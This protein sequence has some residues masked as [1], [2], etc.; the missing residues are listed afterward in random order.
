MDYNC[1]KNV[2][3]N[4]WKGRGMAGAEVL[5]R[6]NVWCYFKG[7]AGTRMFSLFECFLP[8]SVK[9]LIWFKLKC[10]SPSEIRVELLRGYSSQKNLA[11]AFTSLSVMVEM[12]KRHRSLWFLKPH[13]GFTTSVDAAHNHPV[14]CVWQGAKRIFASYLHS[15][16]FKPSHKSPGRCP[17]SQLTPAPA[18]HVSATSYIL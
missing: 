9:R 13:W 3:S 12:V 1:E 16:H 8:S 14:L 4:L 2:V 11:A 5:Q 15:Y 18:A 17:L 10:F 7:R 6:T